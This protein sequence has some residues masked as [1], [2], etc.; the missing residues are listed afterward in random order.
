MV[1]YVYA[2]GQVVQGGPQPLPQSWTDPNT[3][4][5]ITNF[6]LLPDPT[7]LTYDWWPC[8][9][10]TPTYNPLTQYLGAYQYTFDT[11]TVNAE[12]EVLDYT[13]EEID[14]RAPLSPIDWYD[15]APEQRQFVDIPYQSQDRFVLKRIFQTWNTPDD[16]YALKAVLYTP[17]D[18]EGMTVKMHDDNGTYL[19]TMDLVETVPGSGVWEAETHSGS[20]GQHLERKAWRYYIF[21]GVDLTP[22]MRM[23]FEV[24][25]MTHDL[26]WNADIAEIVARRRNGRT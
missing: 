18:A 14:Q 12:R 19:Y 13:E 10:T 6:N 17:E 26:K 5:L 21:K 24:E 7:L 9:I 20:W 16:I 11:T 4:T 8:T 23:P 25:R 15:I 1:D 3:N 22:E 2:P